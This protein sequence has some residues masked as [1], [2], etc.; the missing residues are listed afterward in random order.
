MARRSRRKAR[1]RPQRACRQASSTFNPQTRRSIQTYSRLWPPPS[2]TSVQATPV[3]HRASILV[4]LEYESAGM[5]RCSLTHE[6][7]QTRRGVA[8][9]A[10]DVDVRNDANWR[11]RL[12]KSTEY[13]P[14]ALAFGFGFSAVESHTAAPFSPT[15]SINYL[16]TR[17]TGGKKRS[18]VKFFHFSSVGMT[19]SKKRQTKR[20]ES[21]ALS[22]KR[23]IQMGLILE[24]AS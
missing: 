2:P 18:Q 3:G 17:K 21:T 10:A 1:L 6:Y 20:G 24:S 23:L 13:E 8:I 4:R 22:H 12:A 16:F 14:D 19:G 15:A 9:F 7:G 11:L 5:E